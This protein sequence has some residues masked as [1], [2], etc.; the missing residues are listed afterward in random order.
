MISNL[1]AL[2]EIKLLIL[3]MSIGVQKCRNVGVL[4]CGN[5]GPDIWG[6][7][8]GVLLGRAQRL[9]L[10]TI[11]SVIPRVTDGIGYDFVIRMGPYT[12]GHR[13]RSNGSVHDLVDGSNV[14]TIS[15]LNFILSSIHVAVANIRVLLQGV[16]IGFKVVESFIT[17]RQT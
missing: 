13:E 5:M 9:T 14:V 6:Q 4:E 1:M 3:D 16:M 12:L 11:T 10:I 2:Q 8:I 15:L 17:L 7:N